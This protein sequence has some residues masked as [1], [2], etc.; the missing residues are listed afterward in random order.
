M[1]W[2]RRRK[3]FRKRCGA[4]H[5][6][7]GKEWRGLPTTGGLDNA[8]GPPCFF[9][10]RLPSLLFV[11]ALAGVCMPEP[12]VAAPLELITAKEAA[13]PNLPPT[14]GGLPPIGE[15]VG[16][17]PAVPN[18]PK[19]VVEKP[20]EGVGVHTPFPVKIRFVPSSGNKIDLNSLEIHVVKLIRISLLSRLKPYVTTRGIDV[21]E[22]QIPT[23]TYSIHIAVA[24][25]H[26]H[27]NETTQTWT[28]Q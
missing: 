5:N 10:M 2:Q 12:I 23:G 13:Q 9:F 26:G 28:V 14:K 25:D 18:S 7:L 24:D 3:R 21:P 4:V 17:K 1:N 15:L 11:T 16:S 8:T 19:I 27:R 20:A 22:T 6:S